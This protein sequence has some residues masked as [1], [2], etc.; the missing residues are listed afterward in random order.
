MNDYNAVEF[1]PYSVPFPRVTTNDH[2]K[3]AASDTTSILSNPPTITV[4][5]LITGEETTTALHEI[6]KLL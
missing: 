1:F 4:P 3:Q 2:L 5:S 6:A